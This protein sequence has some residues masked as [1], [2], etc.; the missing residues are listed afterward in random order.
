MKGKGCLV[1]NCCHIPWLLAAEVA[2]AL[3]E[4]NHQM[5]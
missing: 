2:A 3:A 4:E 5:V 1:F